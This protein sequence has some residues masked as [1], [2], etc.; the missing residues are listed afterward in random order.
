MISHYAPKER[1]ARRAFLQ[2]VATVAAGVAALGAC[3]NGRDSAGL[4]TLQRTIAIGPD[5]ALLGGPGEPYAVRTDLAEAKAGRED[6]RVSLIAFH[7]LSDFRI[8][9]E[10]SPAR[11]EWQAD[12]PA[13]S[14]EAF[15][16]QETLSVQMAEALI[17]QA[18]A[19]SRSPATGRAVD[20]AIH[21]GNAADNAQFNELRW[22][23]DMMDGRPVYPD[24]GA[25]GYQ[26]VQ[27][28]S[29]NPNYSNLLNEAQQQFTPEGIR[30]PW[31]AVRGNRDVLAQGSVAPGE[32]AARIATGAQKV[33]VLGPDA[34]QEACVGSQVLLGPDS[35]ST[36]LNDPKTVVR[37]VGKDANRR[38]LATT[39]WLAEHFGTADTP[40]PAGHGFTPDNVA[41][42]TAYYSFERGPVA[43]IV[44]DSVNEAGGAHGSIGEA[45]FAWLE[46]ELISRSSNYISATGATVQTENPDRLIIV[47]SHHASE[48]LNNPFAGPVPEERRYQAP[49]LEAL[50]HRF[51]NVVLHICGH[52]LAHRVTPHAS[53][54]RTDGYWEVTTG[55]PGSWPMQGRL[56]EIVDNRD[57]TLSVLSTVYDS[58]AAIN[59]GDAS[60][61]TP[62]D[63]R[64]QRLYAS[65]ARGLGAR[66]PLRDENA[67]GL[68]PSDRNVELI[69]RAPLDLSSLPE[70]T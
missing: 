65:V 12:C 19:V 6:R 58:A 14:R 22:F 64:N 28:A 46:Q 1:I 31:Y 40:G 17:G 68:A 62:D 55:S 3:S 21:T 23:I 53:T 49:E 54:Q 66:D 4:T 27:T 43:V 15:R 61:P 51:P 67:P 30:Y 9:D 56:V 32:R 25:I 59:P 57:G 10:E 41:A 18:N 63:G 36:I 38:F 44:L 37:S 16:P 42:G 11:A 2:R 48:V 7:H 35:S 39:D 13:P 69:L 33:M 60:D 20:F 45:Q 5:G 50:L 24:S 34:L 70:A 26:G 29:P 8:T 52:T 47:A